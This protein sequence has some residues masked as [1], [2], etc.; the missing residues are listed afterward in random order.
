[1][2]GV[3]R[4]FDEDDGIGAAW[5]L[6]ELE[7]HEVA[8]KL[9]RRMPLSEAQILG[10]L[11]RTDLFQFFPFT[12]AFFRAHHL[13]Q[14]VVTVNPA[15]F[16]QMAERL[17]FDEVVDAIVVSGEGERSTRECCVSWRSSEWRGPVR[18]SMRC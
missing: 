18:M 11:S 13:P 14:A 10:H 6:G 4:S 15:S 1:M 7:T 9:A 5:S 2:D 3:Y 16:R 8:A 12:Y 17:A